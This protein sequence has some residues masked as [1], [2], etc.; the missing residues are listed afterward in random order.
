V[1]LFEDELVMDFLMADIEGS[2]G[3]AAVTSRRFIFVAQTD[4]GPSVTEEHLLSEV[5]DVALVRRGVWHRLRVAWDGSETLI[6]GADREA[7][8]RLQRRLADR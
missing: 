7:L 2:T 8:S 1:E 6:G 5:S 4:S 3:F